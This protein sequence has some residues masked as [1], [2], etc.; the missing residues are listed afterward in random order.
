MLLL[1]PDDAAIDLAG[2]LEDVLDALLIDVGGDVEHLGGDFPQ[3]QV[4]GAHLLSRDDI[5]WHFKSII[6]IDF[7]HYLECVTPFLNSSRSALNLL[8]SSW[9][10][11]TLSISSSSSNSRSVICVIWLSRLLEG[12]VEPNRLGAGVA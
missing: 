1:V 10:I 7:L 9:L 3:L 2:L 5:E 11:N 8:S 12:I 6:G 4:A